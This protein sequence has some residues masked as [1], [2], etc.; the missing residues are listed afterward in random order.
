MQVHTYFVETPEGTYRAV[1]QIT[2]LERQRGTYAGGSG[3]NK[4]GAV[5]RPGPFVSFN[6]P[7]SLICGNAPST[8]GCRGV[9]RGRRRFSGNLAADS[10]LL[11]IERLLLG[12]RDVAAI[13]AGVEA[14]LLADELVLVMQS[15]RAAATDLA[16]LELLIDPPI[17]QVEPRIHFCTTG[18]LLRPGLGGGECRRG[19]RA[20]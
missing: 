13:L 14:L 11:L 18:M 3:I 1:L 20:T 5:S 2:D 6:F 10:V 7:S 16:L 17:L 19:D 4:P 8:E 15:V 9:A 12:A